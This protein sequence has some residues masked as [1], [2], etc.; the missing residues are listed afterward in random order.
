[1]CGS[2]RVKQSEK[3][4]LGLL[5]H[6]GICTTI[7]GNV[8]KYSLSTVHHIPE[9]LKPLYKVAGKLS[10]KYSNHKTHPAQSL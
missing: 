7:L 5:D 9:N 2:S 10:K 4:I 6:E 3:I 1:V 8:G